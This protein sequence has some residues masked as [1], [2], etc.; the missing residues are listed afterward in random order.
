[1][2]APPQATSVGVETDDLK[3]IEVVG[4]SIAAARHPFRWEPDARNS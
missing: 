1:L 3:R 2:I 4:V